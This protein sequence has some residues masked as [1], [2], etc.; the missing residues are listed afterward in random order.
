MYELK[1]KKRDNNSILERFAQRRQ[2]QVWRCYTTAKPF[3]SFSFSET[4]LTDGS[5]ARLRIR[6]RKEG[7]RQRGPQNAS[8][9][10]LIYFLI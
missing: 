8:G 6:R 10:A 5:G 2:R 1:K 4:P 3:D 9:A 7:R